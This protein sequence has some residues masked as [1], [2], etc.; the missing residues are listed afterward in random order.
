[1]TEGEPCTFIL[2]SG[3][4]PTHLTR[5]T[6]HMRKTLHAAHTATATTTRS[7]CTHHGKTTIRTNKNI[8]LQVPAVANPAITT[9]L[10]SVQDL[11]RLNGNVLFTRNKAIYKN[12]AQRNKP[13][14]V[15][16]APWNTKH[17]AYA[18][19]NK[20]LNNAYSARTKTYT[21]T[22]TKPSQNA[23]RKRRR[24]NTLVHAHHKCRNTGDKTG[25]SPIST[26]P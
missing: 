22:Q 3:A 24:C 25:T 17:Q 1:M 5:P 13:I 16:T 23:S 2:D 21:R 6:R 18:W 8:R 12:T 4:H 26:I 10:I 20:N 7:K 15:G 9:N 14:I 19:T 11:A